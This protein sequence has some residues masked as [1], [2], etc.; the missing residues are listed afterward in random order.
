MVASRLEE[1]LERLFQLERLRLTREAALKAL[2]RV[3]EYRD[4]GDQRAR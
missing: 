3:L 2:S 4:L 1:S